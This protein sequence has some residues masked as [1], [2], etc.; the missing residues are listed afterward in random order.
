[1]DSYKL[2]LVTAQ[3]STKLLIGLIVSGLLLLAV[4]DTGFHPVASSL[5]IPTNF[6]SRLAH[7]T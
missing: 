3:N 4:V 2:P 7:C 6:P 5:H 1:M